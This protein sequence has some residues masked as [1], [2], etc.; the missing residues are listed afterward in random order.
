M[1]Q[2]TLTS[3]TIVVEHIKIATERSFAEVRRRL[4]DTLPKLDASIAEV[5]SGG[6]G[7]AL[8]VPCLHLPAVA[9]MPGA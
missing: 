2:A 5:L 8:L 4:E 3:H 6:V 7:V 9:Q 1:P